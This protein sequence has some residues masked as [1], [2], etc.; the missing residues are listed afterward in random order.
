MGGGTLTCDM[1]L[2]PLFQISDLPDWQHG[3]AV[4]ILRGTNDAFQ[5]LSITPLGTMGYSWKAS[6]T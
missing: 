3:A 6:D 1:T 2:L 4:R 5:V